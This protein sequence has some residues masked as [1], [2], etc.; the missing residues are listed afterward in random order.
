MDGMWGSSKH[1]TSELRKDDGSQLPKPLSWRKSHN[2]AGQD[3]TN[4]EACFPLYRKVLDNSNSSR[5]LRKLLN[6][7]VF[8]MINFMKLGS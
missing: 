4:I 7:T 3:V 5:T 1:E 2:T 8:N 6:D